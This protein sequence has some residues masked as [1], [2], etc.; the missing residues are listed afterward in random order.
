M[1][2][3]QQKQQR[4]ALRMMMNV[5]QPPKRRM[6]GGGEW[7]PFTFSRADNFQTGL[8]GSSPKRALNLQNGQNTMFS[9]SNRRSTSLAVTMQKLLCILPSLHHCCLPAVQGRIANFENLPKILL[10]A[11]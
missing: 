9:Y 10:L 4:L 8:L 6:R 11:W 3:G 2:K 5:R 1:N 7:V